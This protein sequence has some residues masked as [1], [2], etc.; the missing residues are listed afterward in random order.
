MTT[1]NSPSSSSSSR[2]RTT[3]SA[4][5]AGAVP[6]VESSTTHADLTD[7]T[8]AVEAGVMPTMPTMPTMTAIP[9]LDAQG[10][11]PTGGRQYRQPYVNP[12]MPVLRRLRRQDPDEITEPEMNALMSFL[13][14]PTG[15][16]RVNSIFL[17]EAL[18]FFAGELYERYSRTALTLAIYLGQNGGMGVSNAKRDISRA[19]AVTIGESDPLNGF[20]RHL[21]L[22]YTVQQLVDAIT[23]LNEGYGDSGT[24]VP[25]AITAA[26]EALRLKNEAAGRPNRY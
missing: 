6:T 10:G 23:Y 11:A 22:R 20:P 15:E 24:I 19:T 7:V 3:S 18:T 26:N 14:D 4:Q 9:E 2:R 8:T 25:G 21:S 5:V 1:S 12:L 17:G 16:V 13:N